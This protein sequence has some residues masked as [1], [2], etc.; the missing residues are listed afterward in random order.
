MSS[1]NLVALT[2]V[3]KGLFCKFVELILLGSKLQNRELFYAR[4]LGKQKSV[5][6]CKLG[7]WSLKV[8]KRL[9]QRLK[10]CQFDVECRSLVDIFCLNLIN[11]GERFYYKG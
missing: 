9:E 5:V 6:I 3:S 2:S 8:L 10:N 7:L 11:C 4:E 1:K